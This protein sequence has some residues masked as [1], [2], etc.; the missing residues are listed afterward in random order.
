MYHIYL[1]TVTQKHTNEMLNYVTGKSFIS[2]QFFIYF[3]GFK[4]KMFFEKI[5][6]STTNTELHVKR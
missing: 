2:L 1:Y 4:K 6:N 5:K 3:H